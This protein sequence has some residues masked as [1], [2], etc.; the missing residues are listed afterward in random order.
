M[1]KN[2]LFSSFG[3]WVSPIF[4]KRFFQDIVESDQDKYVK[5]LSTP[6]YL[7]LFLHAQIQQREGLRA[8][9]DDVLAKSFQRELGFTSISPSQL[10]RKHQQPHAAL[11]H[12]VLSDL[13]KRIR[14]CSIPPTMKRDFR[15]IDSTTIT[16]C[17][18]TYKWATFRETKAGI[19]LHFRLAF[20]SSEDVFPETVQMT[21]ARVNDRAKLDDLVDQTGSTYVFDRGYVDYTKFDEFSQRRIFFVTRTK[22]NAVIRYLHDRPVPQDGPI[23]R[24]CLVEMGTMKHP[25]RLVETKDTQGNPLTLIT[26]RLEL[27]AQEVSEMYRSRWAI[28]TFFKWLKQHV[29][30]TSFFGKSEEAVMNQVLIALIAFCLL[31]LAK[32]FSASSANYLQI[33]RW[34]RAA[35]WDSGEV[36][37]DKLTLHK[38]T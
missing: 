2:T 30:I 21:P 7:K 10:S 8:I 1:D 36:W 19:K 26:N 38:K 25:L 6:A 13:V 29:R 17:L 34:L 3:K 14:S 28:E 5:K 31:V 24:D 37:W 33:Y 23:T 4:S 9:A 12:R 35:L 20:L 18:E 27:T 22:K 32:V 11:L 16:L 15:I